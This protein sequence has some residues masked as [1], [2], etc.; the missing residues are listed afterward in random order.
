MAA[1]DF[2]R[3]FQFDLPL[4]ANDSGPVSPW[5]QNV[6]EKK[7]VEI[8]DPQARAAYDIFRNF[9]EDQ[10]NKDRARLQTMIDNGEQG[11]PAF[12]KLQNSITKQEKTFEN[13][14]GGGAQFPFVNH[15]EFSFPIYKVKRNMNGKL[16]TKEVS[17]LPY[18]ICPFPPPWF[19]RKGNK[20]NGFTAL[21]VP[22]S[23]GQ[24]RPSGPTDLGSDGAVILYDVETKTEYDFWQV[25]THLDA[26]GKS[27]GGG[28]AGDEI[29]STGTVSRFDV[30]GIGARHPEVDPSGSSRASGLPYLGGLLLPEDFADGIKSKIKHALIFAMPQLRYFP[31]RHPDHPP[32]WVY[33]ATRTE[34]SNSIANPNAL[35]AGQRILLGDVLH[36]RGHFKDTTSDL[37][38][39]ESLPPIVRIFLEV[40]H[41]F[42]A[43]LV[44]GAGGFAF[45]AEDIHTANMKEQQAKDLISPHK[46]DEQATP[47]QNVIE[48]LNHYLCCKLLDGAGLAFAYFDETNGFRPNFAVAEDLTSF[49][50]E[51]C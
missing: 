29:L 33:P 10:L 26:Q 19:P 3:S 38:E 32:N 43:Y 20:K 31:D 36:G 9:S 11:T 40:L 44:D 35:A 16:P 7:P 22:T 42:G 30:A 6:K 1:P 46:L 45:A 18:E 47:W 17:C 27:T 37:I 25:T 2:P 34:F 28:I 21:E 4:F 50:R 51:Q 39:D 14:G 15:D 12:E 41:N 23:E 8:S 24:I 48:I 13:G 5:N 49:Y